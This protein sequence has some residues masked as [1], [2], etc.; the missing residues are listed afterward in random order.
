M[1]KGI[2]SNM[3]KKYLRHGEFNYMDREWRQCNKNVREQ[4]VGYVNRDTVVLEKIGYISFVYPGL[5]PTPTPTHTCLFLSPDTYNE[6][7]ENDP[8]K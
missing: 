7:I 8:S 1:R 2:L 3:R 5:T 6:N 4:P